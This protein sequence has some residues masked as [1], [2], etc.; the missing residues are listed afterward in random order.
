MPTTRLSAPGLVLATMCL[1]Q[2]VAILDVT[3]VNLALPAVQRD[4][5]SGITGMQWVVD[6]YVL[7][8]AAL[9]L[10]G[11]TT[12]DRVG[13]KRAFLTGMALFAAGSLLCALAPGLRWLIAGRAVQGVGAAAFSPATLAILTHA[14]PEPGRR[15]RSIGIWSGVSGL[16]LVVGPLVGGSLVQLMG[17]PGIFHLSALVALVALVAAIRVVEESS[18]ARPG[19]VDRLGQVLAAGWLA[20]LTF[21]LIEGPSWG[22]PSPVITGLLV[23]AAAGFAGF[24]LVESRSPSPMLPLSLFR[25]PTFAACNA[26]LLLVGFGLFGSFF[27]L[28]LFLQQVQGYPAVQAGLRLLPMMTAIVLTA[29]LAGRLTARF[30]PRL[31][32]SVGMALTGIGLLLLRL[33]EASTPY[34]SWWLALLPVGLGLGLTMAPTNAALMGGVDPRHAGTASAMASTSQQLGGLVGVAVLGALV[35]THLAG[36]GFVTGMHQALVLAGTGY[37]LGSAIALRFV[38]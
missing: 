20:T 1:A 33:V 28:S 9:L 3:V 15:A 29:P 16:A 18:D 21:A 27:V 38:P 24:L 4:L 36:D 13:R 19:R 22:W 32:M 37:L 5:G 10:T 12:G 6:A 25:G 2:F 11:G 7:L 14:F 17:W 30:G 8:F 26:V 23:L 31:P 34:G 35:S